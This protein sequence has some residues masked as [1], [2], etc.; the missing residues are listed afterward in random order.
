MPTVL[1]HAAAAIALGAAFHGEDWPRRAYAIG[2]VCALL[3]D[4]DVIGLGLGIP[5]GSPL[6]HRGLS[7]SLLAAGCLGGLAL[8]LCFRRKDR[9]WPLF[10]Y[11]VLAAAS[12]GLLDGLTSGGQGIAFFAPFDHARHFL[13]WRPIRVSPLGVSSALSGRFL[14]VLASEARWI[15]A[16]GLLF[17]ALALAL[18][19]IRGPRGASG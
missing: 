6:G 5:Y 9:S 12:H 2:V 15:L 14:A 10:A 1:G 11:F 16:P 3:P 19:R 18:R 7:H 17:A 4:L 13:P 8:V